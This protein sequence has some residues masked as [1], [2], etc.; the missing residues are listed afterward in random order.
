MVMSKKLGGLL[1]GV[2]EDNVVLMGSGPLLSS[3][4][5]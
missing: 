2:S 3:P 1:A 5:R 4:L